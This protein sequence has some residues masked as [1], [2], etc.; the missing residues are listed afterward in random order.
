MGGVVTPH[1]NKFVPSR[2]NATNIQLRLCQHVLVKFYDLA[3]VGVK[4]GSVAELEREPDN[5]HDP[6]C[7]AV[8]IPLHASSS[9]YEGRK[10]LGHIAREAAPYLSQLLEYAFRYSG[11][12]I[13]LAKFAMHSFYLT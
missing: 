9:C 6:N 3:E 10:V 2:V 1:V 11:N 8:F 7:V 4:Y 13:S 12:I 5:P